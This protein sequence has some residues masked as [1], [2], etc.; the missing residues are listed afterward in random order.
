[1]RLSRWEA[2]NFFSLNIHGIRELLIE[3]TR[4][5]HT[6]GFELPS[7]FFHRFLG[8]ENGHMWFFAQFCQRYGGK[9]YQDKSFP[10]GVAEQDAEVANFLVFARI[11]I[12]EELVDHFNLRMGR[13]FALHPLIR[14]VNQVHH[15]DEW[16]HIVMGRKLVGLLYDRLGDRDAEVRE[17]LDEYL[18]RYIVASAESLYNP[19]VYRD[20]GLSKPYAFRESVLNDPARTAYH[21]TFF[22]RITGFLNSQGIITGSPFEGTASA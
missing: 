19:A 3:V 9:I 18:R 10:T 12:F 11:L 4:R 14:E 8:E 17:R 13:D 2:V 1:M 6:T 20:A 5:I 15:D 22:K 7:E 21:Q 16:R